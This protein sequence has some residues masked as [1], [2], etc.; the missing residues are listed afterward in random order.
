MSWRRELSPGSADLL[1]I[2]VAPLQHQYDV[3][4]LREAAQQCHD[5]FMLGK[6]QQLRL[7]ADRLF[8]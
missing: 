5:V 3:G 2:R 4:A 1:Q 8:Q 6:T 7:A